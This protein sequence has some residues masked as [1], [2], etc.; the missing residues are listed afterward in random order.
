MG[1][2]TAAHEA[3]PHTYGR[4]QF[5]Y[6][7]SGTKTRRLTNGLVRRLITAKF[8]IDRVANVAE[9]AITIETQGHQSYSSSAVAHAPT[10]SAAPQTQRA[11]QR[12]TVLMA[13]TLL[14]RG[15]QPQAAWRR[16]RETMA[17]R[18]IDMRAI[19]RLADVCN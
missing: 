14:P 16:V 12:F 5:A 17:E 2:G 6:C 13:A 10:S 15:I 9:C 4:E 1:D 19:E 8:A 11:S 7:T 3:S 18:G